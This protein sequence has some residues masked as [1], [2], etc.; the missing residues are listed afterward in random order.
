M[1]TQKYLSL[2]IKQKSKTAQLSINLT[3]TILSAL[4]HNCI[5]PLLWKGMHK[6][7]RENLLVVPYNYI[8]TCKKIDPYKTQKAVVSNTFVV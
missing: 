8:K 7:A 3:S 2:L 1:C 6:K 4:F 5:I